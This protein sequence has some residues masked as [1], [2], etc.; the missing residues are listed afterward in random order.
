MQK[1]IP[2][3]ILGATG[4]VGQQYLQRLLDHPWFE[5]KFLA[6]SELSAGKSYGE[7][8]A[9]RWHMPISL[10]VSLQIP[11]VPFLILIRA[12][13]SWVANFCSLAAD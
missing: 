8:V 7:A 10:P 13:S 2:V 5:V 12:A 11:Y 1:K 6:A 4:V 9:G 3:G